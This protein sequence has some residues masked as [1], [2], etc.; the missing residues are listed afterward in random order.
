MKRSSVICMTKYI[1]FV[2]K[3]INK[4][5]QP[6]QCNIFYRQEREISHLEEDRTNQ[7]PYNDAQ[8]FVVL[9]YD[10]T[11]AQG[12]EFWRGFVYVLYICNAYSHSVHILRILCILLSLLSPYSKHRYFLMIA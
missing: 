3:S 6:K 11:Q 1:Q 8:N 9:T 7:Q 5:S 2:L 10:R 4:V 12:K